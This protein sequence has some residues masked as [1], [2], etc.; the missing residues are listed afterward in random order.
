MLEF[1]NLWAFL[2][3]FLA[4]IM[5]FFMKNSHL[6]IFDKKIFNKIYVRNSGF[7]YKLR[8]FLLVLSF[9]CAIFA[10]SRPFINNGE[11]KIKQ[12]LIPIIL[13][14]DLS[15]SMSVNDIFPTRFEFAKDKIASFLKNAYNKEISLLGFSSRSFL[16]SPLT[17]DFDAILYL[18]KN[19]N[20]SYENLKGTNFMALLEGVKLLFD[21]KSEK[22]LIIFTDGGENVNFSKEIAFANENN[23]KIFVYLIATKNGGNF[24]ADTGKSVLL[25]ANENI[26]NLAIKTGGD[27]LIFSKNDDMKDLNNLIDAKFNTFG[28]VE[29]ILKNKN[30]LFY[31]PLIL[32]IILYFMANFSLNFRSKI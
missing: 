32:A 15:H 4:I 6:K 14:I 18:L 16:I 1:A 13:A 21:K 20:F 26:K 17:S 8:Q 23:I 22:I 11:I 24:K 29:K 3:L 5:V 19:V 12:N 9:I 30:E 27:F 28:K 10:L 2:L 7:S 31:Y 25:K